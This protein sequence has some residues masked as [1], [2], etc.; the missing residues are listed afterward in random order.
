MS[1]HKTFTFCFQGKEI[2]A[3]P[4]VVTN[5]RIQTLPEI[6]P[7]ILCIFFQPEGTLPIH[8]A[9]VATPFLL[10]IDLSTQLL[11]FSQSRLSHSSQTVHGRFQVYKSICLP[12][13]S[14]C[15]TQCIYSLPLACDWLLLTFPRWSSSFPGGSLSPT[16]V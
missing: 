11:S 5:V 9:S 12:S 7:Q 16:P 14:T 4:L 3:I 8:P 15:H 2:P 6:L 13:F 1:I 10:R